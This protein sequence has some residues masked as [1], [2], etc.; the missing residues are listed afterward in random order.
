MTD[1]PGPDSITVFIQIAFILLMIIFNAL[2]CAGQTAMTALNDAWL[3][4]QADD[5]NKKAK[6]IMR[7]VSESNRFLNTSRLCRTFLCTVITA[8]AILFYCDPLA[9]ALS[10]ASDQTARILSA[11]IIAVGTTF[12][13]MTLGIMLP[14]KVGS[15][16][17]EKISFALTGYMAFV[18]AIFRPFSALNN[19]VAGIFSRLFATD[20]N[21]DVEKVTEEEIRMLVDA[22][23]ENG[24]IEESQKAMINNIFEF[25]DIA[26]SDV[27]T[28][29]TDMVAVDLS[30][31]FD[32]VIHLAINEGYSRIPAYDG[33]IDDIKGIIY[34]KDLLRYVGHELPK[35]GL[36][37]IMRSA[38]FVPETKRCGDLFTEMTEKRIQMCIVSD[39][40][41]G[42]A[43]LVTIEDLLESIVGNIQDEYDDEEEDVEQINDTTFTVDGTTDIDDINEELSI[44]LPDGDYD[45]VGGM[46]MSMIGRIPDAGED[47][48]VEVE[49][50][51]FTVEEVTERRIE[52]VRIEKLPDLSDR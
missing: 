50:C 16:H 4:K 14:K 35:G 26:A 17:D 11:I 10:F 8:C 38:H 20:P 19:A 6:R 32:D 3:E 13:Y 36:A 18:T 5:G 22:G 31:G 37:Q 9:G 51:R 48:S 34:V 52:K 27:M 46:I 47:I 21:A 2:V 12:V 28:H 29:R 7:I 25:D 33:D 40:Y 15:A 24:V 44:E 1:D 23:E 43:G 42:T 45:T 41:G 39:E 49:G 30:A